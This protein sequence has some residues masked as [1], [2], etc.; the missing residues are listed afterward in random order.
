M[1]SPILLI[2]K[3]MM[4]LSNSYNLQ[5]RGLTFQ[6]SKGL[7]PSKNCLTMTPIFTL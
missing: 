3:V 2:E 5:L 6:E 7:P 4:T 1:V